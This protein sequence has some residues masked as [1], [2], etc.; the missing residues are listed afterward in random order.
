MG[1]Q[2]NWGVIL[3]GGVIIIGEYIFID[4]PLRQHTIR[5]SPP[6]CEVNSSVIYTIA[7]KNGYR[8]GQIDNTTVPTWSWSIFCQWEAF[9]YIV[10]SITDHDLRMTNVV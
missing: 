6:L 9:L 2:N 5:C 8:Q 4:A 7:E 1:C 3:I 10:C